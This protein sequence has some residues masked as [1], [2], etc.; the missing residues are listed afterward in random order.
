MLRPTRPERDYHSSNLL[1][2]HIQLFFLLVVK[3]LSVYEKYLLCSFQKIKV[4][5]VSSVENVHFLIYV[6]IYLT[7]D[8]P[9]ILLKESCICS[10]GKFFIFNT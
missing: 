10:Y 4:L 2:T 6:Y 8:N 7:G 3:T 5:F 1:L 9:V